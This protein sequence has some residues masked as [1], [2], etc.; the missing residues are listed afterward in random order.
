MALNEPGPGIAAGAADLLDEVREGGRLTPARGLRLLQS[1]DLLDLGSLAD[2]RRQQQHSER[3]V[4]Y[5]CGGEIHYN[6]TCIIGC[7]FCAR[8]R[9]PGHPQGGR[10]SETETLE[11]VG[12][13]VAAGGRF[14]RLRTGIEPGLDLARHLNLLTAIGKRYDI[15]LQSFSPIEIRHLA[16]EANLSCAETLRRLC[17][18]GLGSL[19]VEGVEILSDRIRRRIAPDRDTVD[20]WLEVTGAAHDLGL[21]TTAS[22]LFGHIE[23]DEDIIEH[24]DQLRRLQDRTGG[25]RAFCPIVCHP[26]SRGLGGEA[27]TKVEYLR[28][29]A[30]SR[31]YLDN[32]SNIQLYYLAPHDSISQPALRFGANDLEVTFGFDTSG[33]CP[34]YEVEAEAVRQISDAGFSPALRGPDYKVVEVF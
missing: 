28:I 15:H 9:L 19:S 33:G 23:S 30:I 25:F 2:E 32:F 26:Q 24:L 7:R 22:L 6:N 8:H 34:G 17:D 4:T 14:V 16:L 13:I 18:A 1:A 20:Q 11:Q 21:G 29:L 3:L 10:L 27:V 31:L 12:M 5:T